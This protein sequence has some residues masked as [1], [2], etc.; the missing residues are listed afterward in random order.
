MCNQV[1]CAEMY[2]LL[3]VKDMNKLAIIIPFYKR[4]SITELCFKNLR[5]QATKYN[6]DVYT[7]GSEG[8]VSESLAKKYGF[9]YL[10]F[11]NLPISRKFDALLGQ[12]KGK[13]YDGVIIIGSDNFIS[14]S[15]IEYYLKADTSLNA[16]YGFTD[17]HFYSTENR[18]LATK[19]AYNYTGM[20]VGVARMYTKELL[21]KAN[22]S[23]WRVDLNSGLDSS[24]HRLM[25]SLGTKEIKIKYDEKY[26]ILDVKHELNITRHEIV[27]TCVD[28]KKHDLINKWCP[29]IYNDI[30]EL[31]NQTITNKT[32]NNTKNRFMKKTK[33]PRATVK[34]EILK[35]VAGM[36]KGETR[37]VAKAIGESGQ[38]KGWCKIIRDT[39]IA[40]KVIVETPKK[41]VIEKVE[42]VKEVKPKAKTTKKSK[43]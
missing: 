43:K 22:Y 23:L 35:N 2:G 19:G 20:S 42:P 40:E 34:I 38:I 1:A 10:E 39:P 26:F 37:T 16:M 13:G 32:I 21:E 4:H 27:N 30:L 28:V 33:N 14:D 18:K 3:V 12:T 29:L 17:L 11:E 15:V 5:S 36:E 24:S 41:E 9:N 25:M 6:I 7:V 8:V 31:S